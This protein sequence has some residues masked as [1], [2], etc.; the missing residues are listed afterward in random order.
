MRIS[1]QQFELPRGFICLYEHSGEFPSERSR[2]TFQNP[3]D[4]IDCD[5]TE[6]F[7]TTERL[8]HN[9]LSREPG[10]GLIIEPL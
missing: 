6:L 1:I 5:S 2:L 10:D 7:K 4:A 8:P 9:Y 3:P